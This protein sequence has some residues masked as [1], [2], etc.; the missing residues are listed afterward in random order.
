LGRN[1]GKTSTVSKLI[2][3]TKKKNRSAKINL[4]AER[5]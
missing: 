2:R 4:V 3:T 5:G 1:I